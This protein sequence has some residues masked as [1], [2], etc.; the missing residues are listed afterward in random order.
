MKLLSRTL[1]GRLKE[2]RESKGWLQQEVCDR[3]KVDQKNYSKY[4]RG[5]ITRPNPEIVRKISELYEIPIDV[6]TRTGVP[7]DH[8][9]QKI[10]EMIEQED[11][12]PF[13]MEAYDKYQQYLQEKKA[14]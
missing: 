10:M 6:L 11:S 5:I 4:E 9:P 3:I 13:L 2:L 7:L 8:I 12:V 1:G 14:Y